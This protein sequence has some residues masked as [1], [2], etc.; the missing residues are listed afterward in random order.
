[1]IRILL[2]RLVVFVAAP[3]PEDIEP[4]NV[5]AVATAKSTVVGVLTAFVRTLTAEQA[6]TAM[7]LLVP[8]MLE[9]ARVEQAAGRE[10]AAR[11]LELAQIEGSAFRAVVA[12]LDADRRAW[13]EE[14]LRSNVRQ[15]VREEEKGGKRIELKMTF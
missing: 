11:L 12:G 2:P 14:V 1:M 6:I 15:E 7:T 4:V 9:R 13:M 10:M 3:T 5:P 8:M